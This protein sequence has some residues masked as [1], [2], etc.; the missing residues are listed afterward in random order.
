MTE[1][2]QKTTISLPVVII[3]ASVVFSGAVIFTK[4]EY[5][6][7]EIATMKETLVSIQNTLTNHYAYRN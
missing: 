1:I 4:V 3:I 6:E 7:R 5:L 2:N